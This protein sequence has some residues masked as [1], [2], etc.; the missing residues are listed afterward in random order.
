MTSLH[1]RAVVKSK[2]LT[3]PTLEDRWSSECDTEDE[4][5]K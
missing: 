4:I 2:S 1:T 5:E 3:T